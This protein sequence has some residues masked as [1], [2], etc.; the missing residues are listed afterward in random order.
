MGGIQGLSLFQRNR[1]EGSADLPSS[2]V[3][4]RMHKN[5]ASYARRLACWIVL[6]T[7]SLCVG[8]Q[9]LQAGAILGFS[10]SALGGGR[11]WDA[12]PRIID[13]NGFN[14]ERSLD[15]GLRYSMMDGSFEFFRNRFTWST[16]PSVA[17]FQAAVQQAFDAWS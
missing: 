12:A 7:L 17:D 6:A 4:L 11:R 5:P 13:V 1:V 9:R 8:A 3:G 15:G 16:L 14:V 10:D 2:S